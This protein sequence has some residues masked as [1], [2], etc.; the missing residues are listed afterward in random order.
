MQEIPG[1]SVSKFEILLKKVCAQSTIV[2]L[3]R[4]AGDVIEVS[5]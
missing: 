4:P 2:Y 1:N 5:R 3:N